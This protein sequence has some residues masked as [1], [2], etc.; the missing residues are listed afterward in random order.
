M[1]L[2]KFAQNIIT[3]IL[4]WKNFILIK[5]SY[6]ILDYNRFIGLTTNISGFYLMHEASTY[7]IDTEI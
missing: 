1:E 4:P 7:N 3:G 2:I 5:N 6:L